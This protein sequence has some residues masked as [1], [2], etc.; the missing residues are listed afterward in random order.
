MNEFGTIFES[1]EHPREVKNF[2]VTPKRPFQSFMFIIYN[3]PVQWVVVYC[4]EDTG[5]S[6]GEQYIRLFMGGSKNLWL[7][8]HL[9]YVIPRKI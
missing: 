4:W 2:L 7:L 3:Y 1:K 8:L 5:P 9:V 6:K